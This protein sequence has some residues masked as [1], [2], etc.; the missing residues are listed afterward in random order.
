MT[1]VVWRQHRNEALIA[2]CL[3]VALAVFLLLTGLKVESSAREIENYADCVAHIQE[4]GSCLTG[5]GALASEYAQLVL[6]SDVLPLLPLLLGILV[7]APLVPRELEQRTH[8]LA[9]TQSVSRFRWL[10]LKLTLV[11]GVSL[12]IFSVLMALAIW[13]WSPFAYFQGSFGGIAFD[14]TGPVLPA[15]ALLALALGILAGALT[16]RT[17]FAIFL[18]IVLFLAIRLPVEALWRP[19]FIPSMTLTWP[20]WQATEPISAQDWTIDRHV[21]DGQGNPAFA[22]ACAEPY[23]QC[24]EAK[25]FRVR[26]VYQPADR[27]WTFQ[28]IETGIYLGFTVLALGAT[29]WLVRRLA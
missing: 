13:W 10:T 25:G 12:L 11:L 1:W 23:P 24:P 16:R 2:V 29:F 3:L 18:T 20:V 4:R 19:N 21:I 26:V 7:G 22:P 9:W 28:W 27:F 6:F 14:F 8:L 17:V 5:S 15:A